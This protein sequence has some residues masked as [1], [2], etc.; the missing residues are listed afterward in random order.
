MYRGTVTFSSPRWIMLPRVYYAR[1]AAARKGGLVRT[2]REEDDERA[3]VEAAQRDP[4]RFAELYEQNFY[5]IYAYI[6]R[7]VAD[8]HQ[9]KDLTTNVFREAL[10]GIENF[11]F[12]GVPFTT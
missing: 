9:A 10:A 4:T 12:H 3:Q 11:E 6:L 1:L 2:G 5:R 7:R 8:R